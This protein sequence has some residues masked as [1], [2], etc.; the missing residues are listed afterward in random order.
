MGY[1][2]PRNLSPRKFNPWN[3]VTTKICAYTVCLRRVSMYAIIACMALLNLLWWSPDMRHWLSGIIIVGNCNPSVVQSTLAL[4]HDTPYCLT[5]R[6][7]DF[8]CPCCRSSI[9]LL[10]VHVYLHEWT[11]LITGQSTQSTWW[12]H[13]DLPNWCVV[14][15]RKCNTAC[16][17][18]EVIVYMTSW[19]TVPLNALL[20]SIDIMGLYW[21]TYVTY[22]EKCLPHLR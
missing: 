4:L 6:I 17:N 3:I 9:A 20:L 10:L 7:R 8:D 13:N 21:Y 18:K 1:A 11:L 2:Q 5:H 14:A 12:G 19:V 16:A 15:I 22:S